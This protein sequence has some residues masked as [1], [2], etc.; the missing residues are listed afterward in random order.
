L[1][2]TGVQQEPRVVQQLTLAAD[3]FGDE[4]LVDDLLPTLHAMVDHHI[5]GTGYHIGVDPADG[6]L[7]AGEPGVQLTW[8]D[9]KVGDWVVTPRIGKPVEINALWYNVLQSLAEALAARGHGAAQQ[10]RTRGVGA[11]VV[12]CPLPARRAHLSGRRRGHARRRRLDAAA[13]P[14]LRRLL[15]LSL[16]AWGGG[17]G[18]RRGRGTHLADQL[19]A[20]LAQ[21]RRSRLSRNVWRGPGSARWRVPSGSRLDVA[22]G[23]RR[24]CWAQTWLLGADVVVHYRVYQDREVALALPQPFEDHLRDAGLGSISEILEMCCACPTTHA[25]VLY[26]DGGPRRM[27]LSKYYS[28]SSGERTGNPDI[29]SLGWRGSCFCSCSRG[30]TCEG[31]WSAVTLHRIP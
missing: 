1:R 28:C 13:Q 22:A 16:A 23:R 24:G 27:G 3:Q 30:E 11:V 10:Y 25:A 21:F 8:M 14:N 19:R 29:A 12:P 15:T 20:A 9:A 17:P 2:R 26:R 31:L 5:Q 4:S 7:Y 6:L 18:R